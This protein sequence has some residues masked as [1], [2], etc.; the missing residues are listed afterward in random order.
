MASAGPR[1]ARRALPAAG[2]AAAARPPR[3]RALRAGRGPCLC[4]GTG[5][6]RGRSE[7]GAGRPALDS[8]GGRLADVNAR[9]RAVRPRPLPRRPLAFRHHALHGPHVA[10]RQLAGVPHPG[11]AG[12]VKRRRR[13][14][15]ARLRRGRR[16]RAAGARARG[17][18][19]PAG[20]M[21]A[22]G[23]PAGAAAAGAARAA[24]ARRRRR[25][26]R[27]RQRE[28]RRRRGE[29]ARAGRSAARSHDGG[30]RGGDAVDAQ[31]YGTR[32]GGDGAQAT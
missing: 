25:R 30:H 29:R 8:P 5:W 32:R 17:S 10:R 4:A 21:L 2:R 31:A 24:A 6:R 19:A 12:G 26:R 1:G 3:R 14:E 11:A 7:P 16:K 23:L 15:R 20:A 27:R 13:V 18:D 22:R 28:R 9:V